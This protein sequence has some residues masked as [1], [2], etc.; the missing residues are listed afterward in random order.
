[1]TRTRAV[2]AG[3]IIGLAWAAGAASASPRIQPVAVACRDV[4]E[5]ENHL[6]VLLSPDDVLH[7]DALVAREHLDD[8]TVAA[9]DGARIVIAAQPF[10]TAAWLE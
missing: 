10:V 2:V 8:L 3:M 9:G 5:A 1:M 7:V 6:S 4:P